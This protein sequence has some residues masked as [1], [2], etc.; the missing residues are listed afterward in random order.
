MFEIS[1]RDITAGEAP[2]RHFQRGLEYEADQIHLWLL[3]HKEST[4]GF[5]VYFVVD[6]KIVVHI[7][8]PLVDL[9]PEVRDLVSK[10]KISSEAIFI[11]HRFRKMGGMNRLLAE[12]LDEAVRLNVREIDVIDMS[13]KWL[14]DKLTGFLRSS[15][16]EVSVLRS[17][18][19]EGG[20]SII[21]SR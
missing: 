1:K 3:S 20:S 21:A 18:E 10:E 8:P 5:L 17:R 7:K 6:N 19:D 13:E 9:G 15:S 4:A 12:L 11:A 14:I 2:V 16:Y